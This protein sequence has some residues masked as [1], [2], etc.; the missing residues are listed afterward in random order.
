[1]CIAKLQGGLRE[2]WHDLQIMPFPKLRVKPTVEVLDSP[3]PLLSVVPDHPFA[4]VV[5]DVRKNK[6]YP[7]TGR[8]IH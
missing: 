8:T 3:F 1:M 2:Y 7:R 6:T 4:L 5:V